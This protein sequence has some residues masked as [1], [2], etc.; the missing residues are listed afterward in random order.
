MKVQ[1]KSVVVNGDTLFVESGSTIDAS[2]AGFKALQGPG[3]ATILTMG[4]SFASHGGYGSET[5]VYGHF[6]KQFQPGS[7]GG[8]G[9][10]GGLLRFQIGKEV[11]I[12]G[13]IQSRGQSTSAAYGAGSG[14]CIIIE[15]FDLRGKGSITVNGGLHIYL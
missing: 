13:S 1:T 14:G 9:A 15:T 4:G 6:N 3:K 2:N 10:G 11:V 8:A 7:G 12:D 5:S